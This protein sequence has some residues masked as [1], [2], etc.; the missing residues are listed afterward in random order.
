MIGVDTNVLL[1]FVLVDDPDQ[2]EIATRF[3][4]DRTRA[5]PAYV[6]SI[7]LVETI[8][9]LSNVVKVGSESIAQALLRMLS[10]D[11][12]RF[13]DHNFLLTLFADRNGSKAGIADLLVARAAA[14]AGCKRTVTFDR[15]AARD[16][17]AIELLA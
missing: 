2:H 17:P 8:W 14:K 16:I 12:I 1:R 5:D 15:K 4:G 9:Y 10:V 7:V 6:S 11:E 13:E 3:F